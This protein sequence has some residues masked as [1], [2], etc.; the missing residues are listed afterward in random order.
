MLCVFTLR[1]S[2]LG[3]SFF[4]CICCINVRSE[5][6]ISSIRRMFLLISIDLYHDL[7]NLLP[8][9]EELLTKLLKAE[10]AV[11][12]AYQKLQ[13]KV[14]HKNLTN[15]GVSFAEW[16]W[17]TLLLVCNKLLSVSEGLQIIANNYHNLRD[18]FEIQEA[19][20]WNTFY[21]C[22]HSIDFWAKTK[23]LQHVAT[24]P[25]IQCSCTFGFVFA[26]V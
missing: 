16:R 2:V 12:T 20:L 19:A 24:W 8:Y 17:Q 1:H 26:V 7:F 11:L 25:Y 15:F 23:L 3:G 21:Y 6:A 5:V 18:E 22:I 10:P 9:D 4:I 14:A 13:G